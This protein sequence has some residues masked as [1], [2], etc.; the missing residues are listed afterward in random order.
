[1]M[2][3]ICN[4]FCLLVTASTWMFPTVA[5]AMGLLSPC[6]PPLLTSMLICPTS[7]VAPMSCYWIL[8][9][10]GIEFVICLQLSVRGIHQDLYSLLLLIAL[11][12]GNVQLFLKQYKNPT[13]VERDI[14]QIQETLLHYRKLQVSEKIINSLFRTRV[15]LPLVCILPLVQILSGTAFLTLFHSEGWLSIGVFLVAWLDSSFSV[16]ISLSASSSVYV[17]SQNWMV[18]DRILGGLMAGK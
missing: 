9:T 10:C 15:F 12:W 4:L 11:F 3:R 14:E 13:R 1:M 18:L 17:R 16:M 6:K 2:D 7:I 8:V 5:V